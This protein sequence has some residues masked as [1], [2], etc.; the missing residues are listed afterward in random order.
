MLNDLIIY[1]PMY[2]T[3]FWAILLLPTKHQE[4]RAKYF[5]GVFMFVA[6]LL[7]VSHAIYFNNRQEIYMYFDPVYTFASLSVYPLY[8]WYIKLLTVETSFQI[9]NLKMLL[10]AFFLSIATMVVY[11]FMTDEQRQIY[12]V[13]VLFKNQKGEISET[14]INIQ[15][16]IYYASR[17]VFSIQVIYFLVKGSRLVVRYNNNICNFYSNLESKTIGWVNLLL[18]S[19][20]LTSIMSIA[21]NVLGKTVFIDSTF[22]LL[23][24]SLIF[25][26]LLFMI[27]YQGYMQNYTVA[28]LEFDKGPIPEIEIKK[29]NQQKLKESLKELF[30]NQKIYTQIDLKITHVSE[31]LNTN[32]TYISNIINKEFACS[33]SEFVNRYRIL[34]A[35]KLLQEKSSKNYSL[36]HISEKAGFGSLHTF[37]RVFKESEGIT[38]GR[39]R[40]QVYSSA[41]NLH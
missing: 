1:T 21:F 3:F 7:Y 9:K 17:L 29:I 6:F 12:V 15:K 10:P 31:M 28:D 19:F 26:L 33:F 8:Y 5:L 13:G 23:I 2:I 11:M 20:V 41:Q 36:D 34:E 22:H 30:V 24:P 16:A 18:Y 35:K 14:I 38:P 39:F 4:N 32:R 40:D 27:G 25:S 37:I